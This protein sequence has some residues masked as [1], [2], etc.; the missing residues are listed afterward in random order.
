MD[1][2]RETL[3]QKRDQILHEAD[4]RYAFLLSYVNGR[5]ERDVEKLLEL[6]WSHNASLR[7]FSAGTAIPVQG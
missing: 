3:R 4:C 1:L 2:D 7:V 6:L 5:A